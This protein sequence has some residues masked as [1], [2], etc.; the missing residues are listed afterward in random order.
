[1]VRTSRTILLKN[2]QIPHP[3]GLKVLANLFFE[4]DEAMQKVCGNIDNFYYEAIFVKIYLRIRTI[5]ALPWPVRTPKFKK[6]LFVYT[7]EFLKDFSVVGHLRKG[8]FR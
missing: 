1:M 6:C 5:S 2:S 8:H 3:L 7:R 4:K